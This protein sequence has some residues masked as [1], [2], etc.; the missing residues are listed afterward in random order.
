MLPLLT[1]LFCLS[2]GLMTMLIVEQGQTID[3][4]RALI[5]EL[6]RDSTALSAMKAEALKKA[7]EARAQAPSAK[8]PSSQTP[9]SQIPSSV[10]PST[11]VPAQHAPSS[12]VVQQH[13]AQK[14][15]QKP[16]FRMP[17]RP[18]SDLNDENRA[19]VTI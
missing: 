12:Q 8:S 13:Q 15:N 9:S 5:R 3:Q 4:Q 1:V 14:E 7:A 6:F 18:A 16:L 2:Y 19:L 10:A 11:Q 17:S